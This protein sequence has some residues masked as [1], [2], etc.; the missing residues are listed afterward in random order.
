MGLFSL[1]IFI[2]PFFTYDAGETYEFAL[3][4]SGRLIYPERFLYIW[5]F[6]FVSAIVAIFRITYEKSFVTDKGRLRL[7]RQMD[8]ENTTNDIVKNQKMNTVQQQQSDTNSSN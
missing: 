8:I 5:L 3:K 7:A 1:F 4:C 2:D 6:D